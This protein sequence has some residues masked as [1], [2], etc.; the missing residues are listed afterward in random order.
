MSARKKVLY[1]ITKST[2]GG[3]QRYVYDLATS[4]P[5]EEFEAVVAA[6]G[7]GP[8]FTKL[9][10]AG[11]RTIPLVLT[12]RSNFLITLLTFGSLFPLLRILREERPDVLHV[13]SAKAGG[14]GAFAGRIAG[15]PKIIFTAHG[16]SFLEA[17]N[18][19]S[20]ALI[21]FFSWLTALLSHLV[22]VVSR[23]DLALARCMPFL[24]D[25]ILHIYNGI[26]TNLQFGSGEVIRK[27]FPSHAR[28]VGTVGELTRNKNQEA[29][30]EEAASKKDMFVAI[31]GEG[32]DR[33]RLEWLIQAHHL[34]SRVKLFGF[35]PASDVLKG[36]DEFA[37]P[38]LKE[39]LPYVLLE[40][41]AAGLPLRA[42]RVGG[43]GEIIDSKDMQSFTLE[44]MVE[45]T[46]AVYRS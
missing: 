14:L 7:N 13:N 46:I 4:L 27:E 19:L 43:V 1:L 38:S 5:K 41:K 9:A 10:A 40:A 34:E 26:D 6:G 3:A 31:V 30:I 28:I 17:R 15:I 25:K 37:L 16:W 32:E 2:W 12:Q 44:H 18:V 36:F 42:N 21:Y 24:S 11:I 22:I 20:K 39:G 8:L 45:E 35:I 33:E 29:L 23:H